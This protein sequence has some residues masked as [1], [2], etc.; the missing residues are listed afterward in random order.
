MSIILNDRDKALQAAAYRTTNTVV[1]ITAS[2]GAAFKTPKNGGITMPLINTLTATASINFTAAAV[3]TWQYALSTASSSWVT[4]GTGTSITIT[5][6]S[7]LA[8]LGDAVSVQYRCTVTEPGI[9]TASG[10]YTITYSKEASEP[11]IV[12]M[13]RSSAVIACSSTGIPTSYTNTDTTISVSRGGVLLSY[14]ALPNIAN[15]FTVS[16]LPDNA[17]RTVGTVSSTSTTYGISGI[18]AIALDIALRIRCRH[19]VADIG[20]RATRKRGISNF[21]WSCLP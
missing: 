13:T 21:C 3:Y 8:L 10:W 16:I 2:N 15:S 19:N 12:D 6:T 20:P 17:A 18:T 11:I 14:S 1:S 5:N 7:L 4:I 9:N